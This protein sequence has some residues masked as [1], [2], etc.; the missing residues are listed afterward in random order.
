MVA[1]NRKSSAAD[2]DAPGDSAAR[3]PPACHPAPD[4]AAAGTPAAAV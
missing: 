1:A 4:V 3:I 2:D